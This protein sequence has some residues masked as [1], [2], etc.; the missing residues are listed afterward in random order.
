MFNLPTSVPNDPVHWDVSGSS[1]GVPEITL[2][3]YIAKRFA[4]LLP[5]HH[6]YDAW[7]FHFNE[8]SPLEFVVNRQ[9]FKIFS[10]QVFH[11]RPFELHSGAYSIMPPGKFWFL[12][13]KSPNPTESPGE[14]FGLRPSERIIFSDLLERLPRCFSVPTHETAWMF[15]QIRNTCT[16]HSELMSL[17]VRIHL[18]ELLLL[19]GRNNTPY[20]NKD[21]THASELGP[22]QN[23]IQTLKEDLVNKPEVS[24]LARLVNLSTPSFYV[25]FRA[26]YGMS[27][28]AYWNRERLVHVANHLLKHPEASVSKLAVEFGYS[29]P[30]Q[31]TTNFKRFFGYS[32]TTWRQRFK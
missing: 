13:V 29:S 12:S 19:F 28:V 20:I 10:G 9:S 14:W 8:G 3:G 18:L 6:H 23:V 26:K 21:A 22:W 31:L 5:E 30:Q 15:N 27:P 17:E 1:I 16:H 24:E 25:Q 2:M 32:P 11:T 4:D 7:E